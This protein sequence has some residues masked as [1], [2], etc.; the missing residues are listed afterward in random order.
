MGNFAT[1]R[2]SALILVLSWTGAQAAE[3]PLPPRAGYTFYVQ[4]QRVG[5]CDVR[6]TQ[7]DTALRFESTLRVEN[8][9]AVI[10]L[11]TKAEADPRTYALRSFSYEGTKGGMP[12]TASVTVAGDSVFGHFSLNGPRKAQRR[13]VNPRPVVVW[14]DW[15]MEIE[16]LLA[17][18]QAREFK[19]PSTRALLLAGS[20][21]STVVT[22]G[23]TGEA[24]VESADRSMTA[25]KLVVG[26]EGGDPFESLIDPKLGVPVYIHFPGIRAEAFLD[27]FFGDNPSPRYS[28]ATDTSSGR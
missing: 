11:S 25:R 3:T 13:S 1:A 16:I 21:T 18:Q 23:F 9:S 4:G 7:T 17:L 8:G 20:F 26:I 24:V 6:I 12:A 15:A 22:L 19:N 5:R 2:L 27:D 10:E 14:E 28:P